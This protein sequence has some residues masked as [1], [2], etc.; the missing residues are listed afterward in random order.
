MTWRVTKY[1]L[2][3]CVE[4]IY[5]KLWNRFTKMNCIFRKLVSFQYDEFHI[6]QHL[7]AHTSRFDSKLAI[8]SRWIENT[9]ICFETSKNDK[10]KRQENEWWRKMC[11]TPAAIQEKEKE[12]FTPKGSLMRII[13][14]RK[15][16]NHERTTDYELKK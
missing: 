2:F 14:I 7:P 10:D 11:T 16:R 9:I 6:K 5:T 12:R 4:I 3:D 15:I 13:E 1:S 8:L